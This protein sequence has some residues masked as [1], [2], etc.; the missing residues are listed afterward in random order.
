[1]ACIRLGSMH[2][3]QG[4]AQCY[5]I[6]LIF[7]YVQMSF[8]KLCTVTETGKNAQHTVAKGRQSQFILQ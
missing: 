5:F 6:L 8:F 3:I 1:M 4:N 2:V 7:A